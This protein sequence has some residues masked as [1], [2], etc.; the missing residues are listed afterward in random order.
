MA[1]KK[2]SIV[3]QCSKLLLIG[4]LLLTLSH[5]FVIP[6]FYSTP[7]RVGIEQGEVVQSIENKVTSPRLYGRDIR[8]RPYEVTAEYAVHLDQNQ[9]KLY[10]IM[11]YIGFE[12]PH[13]VYSISSDVGE[14]K[15]NSN[16][17]DLS[18]NVRLS[19][20]DGY[21]VT[22]EKVTIDCVR[23]ALYTQSGVTLKWNGGTLKAGKLDIPAGS[24]TL[25]FK[26]PIQVQLTNGK[27]Q[28]R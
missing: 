5:V 25:I 9:M 6:L 26:G 10:K 1:S 23:S 20:D 11:G 3:V 13:R 28:S 27:S 22:T 18:G 15:I 7:D 4:L 8:G 2:Y 14:T 19:G 16:V 21:V 17:V 24:R 12:N